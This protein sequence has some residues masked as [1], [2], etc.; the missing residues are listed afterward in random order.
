MNPSQKREIEDLLAASSA[1]KLSQQD[2]DLATLRRYA[3]LLAGELGQRLEESSNDKP[4]DIGRP[5]TVPSAETAPASTAREPGGE[6]AAEDAGRPVPSE[7]PPEI[8]LEVARSELERREIDTGRLTL[9]QFFTAEQLEA[10]QRRIRTEIDLHPV[11]EPWRRWD[12]YVAVCLAG[13]LAGLWELG[14][15]TLNLLEL[16]VPAGERKKFRKKREEYFKKMGGGWLKRLYGK[17]VDGTLAI[18]DPSGQM[19]KNPMKR[20][21][22]DARIPKALLGPFETG[23]HRGVGPMHDLC[24]IREAVEMM[25]SEKPDFEVLGKSAA[26]LAGGKL[27]IIGTKGEEATIF[28]VFSE[29]GAAVIAV[30]FHLL[31]DVVTKRSLPLPGTTWVAD[32]SPAWRDRMMTLYTRGVNVKNVFGGAGQLS[33]PV[34]TEAVLRLYFILTYPE[35]STA[36]ESFL[37]RGLRIQTRREREMLLVAHGIAAALGSLRFVVTRALWDLNT[38]AVLAMLPHAVSL[39]GEVQ[40]ARGERLE[41]VLSHTAKLKDEVDALLIDSQ[42]PIEWLSDAEVDHALGLSDCEGAPMLLA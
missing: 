25:L 17:D 37:V 3:E 18:L 13:M 1:D 40:R 42:A 36:L 19:I 2:N 24:R 30:L 35:G 5:A 21:V 28:N 26:G 31:S 27:R 41:G 4:L 33:S 11:R 39:L 22:M 16:G 12:D 10:H 14:V 7:L 6:P 15:K 20:H 32:W 34:I 9:D 23:D 8:W 29:P 38:A